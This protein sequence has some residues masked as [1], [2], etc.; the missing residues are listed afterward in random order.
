MSANDK[1]RGL[2]K[3]ARNVSSNAVD[4][5][6]RG[7]IAL[8]D[9]SKDQFEDYQDRQK[10]L[11][12]DNWFERT[13]NVCEQLSDAVVRENGWTNKAVSIA[14][15]KLIGATVPASFFS[16]AALVGTASTGTAIGSLSGAAF[17]SSALAW[18]GGSVAMGTLVVSGAAIAGAVAAP[19]AIKPIANKYFL[20]KTRKLEDLSGPE[21]QLVDACSALAL[22]LRQAEKGDLSLSA[23]DASELDDQALRPL[24]EKASDVLWI[25][26]DWPIVQRRAFRNAFTELCFSR[27]FAKQASAS[28]EP[29]LIGVGTALVFNLLSEG[30][31]TF[32][33][34]EQDILD[35]IRRSSA[36]LS[37]MSNEEIAEYVQLFSPAQLQGFKNNVKG[38]AHELQYARIEN[39]DGDEFR[40]ELFEATNHPGA[41]VKI[42]NVETGEIRDFQL[43]ATSYGSYVETHFERYGETPVMTT[44]EVAEKYG[45]HSTGV[46]NVQLSEDFDR[47]TEMLA[48][49]AEPDV[50]DSMAIAGL[51][52]LA[53]N[54]RLLL[55]DGSL[56]KEARTDAVKRSMQA[57]LVAGI[58]ELLI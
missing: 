48:T 32:T 29:V 38:I 58:T 35:A 34:A 30:E 28:A 44:S 17:T 31:H 40:V 45:F 10:P 36:N 11:D 15:S 50:L 9:W 26:R 46:S 23:R 52:S 37:E 41:D 14:S 4:Q 13:A 3:I 55:D 18:I 16:I 12:D 49:D 42:I 54:V 8:T 53:R 6:K 51:V 22:G 47:T 19:F 25:S 56:S 43:K 5:A 20:G 57:G 1:F 2:A 24:A 7:S 33:A 21:K 27:G 39:S